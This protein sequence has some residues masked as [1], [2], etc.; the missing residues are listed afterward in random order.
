[1]Q[2]F[3]KA[4]TYLAIIHTRADQMSSGET[5]IIV[6][7]TK[8]NTDTERSTMP[9]R[10]KISSSVSMLQLTVLQYLLPPLPPTCYTKLDKQHILLWFELVSMLAA[11]CPHSSQANEH[12]GPEFA[13]HY[14]AM[15]T[16]GARQ[17]NQSLLL[18]LDKKQAR[19]VTLP[20]LGFD[21]T[22]PYSKRGY[23]FDKEMERTKMA[24]CPPSVAGFNRD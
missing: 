1:M 3:K 12:A 13:L 14:I 4:T 17:P 9:C 21:N 10:N 15:V 24:A 18:I 7:N 22:V 5:I 23:L 6:S 20:W 16:T 2:G 19:L 11:A 8:S